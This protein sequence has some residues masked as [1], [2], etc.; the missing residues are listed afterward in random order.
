MTWAQE[1]VW[2]WDPLPGLVGLWVDRDGRV[3]RWRREPAT[4]ALRR[5][6]DHFR[7]WALLPTVEGLQAAG[8]PFREIAPDAAADASPPGARLVN[9][10]EL[11]GVHPLQGNGRLRYLVSAPHADTL[12]RA[13][14]LALNH[15]LRRPITRL[16]GVDPDDLLLLSLEDQYLTLSGQVYFRGLAWQD[17]HR[18]TFDLETEGLDPTRHRIFLIAVRDTRG[19][20]TVLDVGDAAEA[21]LLRRFV[22]LVQ[23]RDPDV[24]ENHNLAGF[25]LPFLMERAR[26][27]RIP[28]ALQRRGL[29]LPFFRA[30]P[31]ARAWGAWRPSAPISADAPDTTA[32][33]DDMLG[34]SAPTESSEDERGR[35][36]QGSLRQPERQPPAPPRRRGRVVVPGREIIDTLDAVRRYDF[37]AR[38]LPGH[39][40]KV[41][42]QALGAAPENREYL[43]GAE[44]GATWQVDPERVRRYALDD[45]TEAAAVSALLGGA[46]FALAQI[47]P[48][49]YERVAEAGPATGLLDPLLVRAYLRAGVALPA[50]APHKHGGHRLLASGVSGEQ[51]EEAHEDREDRE[52]H[53]EAPEPHSGGATYLFASGVARQVVKCDIASL[54]PSLIRHYRLGPRRDTLGAFL[55]L[56][57]Q[58]VEQRLAA[59]RQAQA[60]APG[61]VERQTQAASAAGLKI[62]I[63][64]AYGYL[65]APGLCRLADVA[66][67]NQ[68][69]AYGRETLD[70]LCQQLVERGV[71]LLEADTDGVYFAV[72]A[73]WTEADERR[74]VAEVGATLPPL[75]ALEY[76]ARYAAM[77]SHEVKNYA[78]LS[79]DGTLTLRGVAFHSRRMEPYGEAFLRQALRCLLSGDIPGVR[80][81]Y[82]ET[83]RRLRRREIPIAEVTVRARLTKSPQ[84]YQR[85]RGARRESVYEAVLASGWRD[86][87]TGES[88]QYY[89][90]GKGQFALWRPPTTTEDLDDDNQTFHAPGD[91]TRG[92]PY[93]TH[94]YCAQLRTL[95]AQRLVRAFTPDDF[96]TL[97]A[98]PDQPS[99][100]ATPLE[101]IRPQLVSLRSIPNSDSKRCM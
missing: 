41:V 29:P 82:L 7:P 16:Q 23:A 69:T 55:T 22:A 11:I 10:L 12:E 53:E 9:D 94:Y 70:H 13:L 8:I 4:G 52:D 73:E 86:W 28:L 79:D 80:A 67:A 84:Q 95:Y 40:L 51:G 45:V 18:L 43:P 81:A 63:N 75:V 66:V 88:V 2:G 99:L 91:D 97:F 100:F 19:L 30:A 42:A 39:G 37:S 65:A 35:N 62:V 50:Y 87:E 54:Y 58:L 74:C 44:V 15:T 77:L 1:I 17:V 68:V 24:L 26:R 90:V 76:E 6:T 32:G 20:A 3:T 31:P 83:I 36:A 98:D 14:R 46:A 57:D 25:D 56:M 60:A 101:T 27:L 21:D 96:A 5:E 78:T 38:S 61:S 64:A 85:T 72:P 71:T 48:R 47:A 89:C 92:R 33:A 93:D 59:K 49:R 34:A